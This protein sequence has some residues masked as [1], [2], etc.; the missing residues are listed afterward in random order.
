MEYRNIK[1]SVSFNGAA[2]EYHIP[3]NPFWKGNCKV[4]GFASKDAA[5]DAAHVLINDWYISQ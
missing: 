1:F 5:V 3:P 2:W 4:G